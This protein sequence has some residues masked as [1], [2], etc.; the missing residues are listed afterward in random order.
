[1]DT[2]LYQFI[3]FFKLYVP[4]TPAL[5]VTIP[6]PDFRTHPGKL[7]IENYTIT[8][9]PITDLLEVNELT[10]SV[11]KPWI[12]AFLG[13]ATYMIFFAGVFSFVFFFNKYFFG[14]V[15]LLVDRVFTP[16]ALSSGNSN[17]GNMFTFFFSVAWWFFL[18]KVFLSVF[19]FVQ[20]FVP[21]FLAIKI[22]LLAIISVVLLSF[23]G[24]AEFAFLVNLLISSVLIGTPIYVLMLISNKY[25]HIN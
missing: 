24:Y 17:N 6:L 10:D 5:D 11:Y 1:V 15:S 25:G 7:G 14:F 21:L 23:G 13:F 9:E 12:F 4:E 3:E 20:I 2:G 22:F 16:S 19:V 18:A 8:L